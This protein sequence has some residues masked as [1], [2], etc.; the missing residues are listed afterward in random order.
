MDRGPGGLQSIEWQR[1]T[2]EATEHAHMQVY[3]AQVKRTGERASKGRLEKH[4]HSEERN[5]LG[6]RTKRDQKKKKKTLPRLLGE[7]MSS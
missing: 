1:D 2:T 5:G 3:N 6:M 7:A 4:K